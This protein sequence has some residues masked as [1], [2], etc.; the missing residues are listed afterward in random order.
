MVQFKPNSFK[1]QEGE[2]M[3]RICVHAF[4]IA[5]PYC[6]TLANSGRFKWVRKREGVIAQCPGTKNSIVMKIE[7]E[8]DRIA[9]S[10]I[11][12]RGKCPNNHRVGDAF[13][14]NAK[15]FKWACGGV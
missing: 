5:Y 10:I 12:V 2:P 8:G 15:V 6:L 14:F 3:N 11:D 1:E 7:K 9:V 13:E 4:N